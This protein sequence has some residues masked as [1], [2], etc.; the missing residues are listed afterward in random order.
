VAR[1]WNEERVLAKDL[2]GYQK[3]LQRIFFGVFFDFGFVSGYPIG[4]NM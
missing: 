3:Y 1:I 4:L 2:N